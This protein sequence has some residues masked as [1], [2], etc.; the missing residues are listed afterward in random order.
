VATPELLQEL[1]NLYGRTVANPPATPH[2]IIRADGTTTDLVTGI[3]ST[4][5]VV[6]QVQMAMQ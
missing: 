5:Q 6:S 4:D 1:S 3:D 2:F